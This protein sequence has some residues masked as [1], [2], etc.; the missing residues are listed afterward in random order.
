M[1]GNAFFLDFKMGW[2]IIQK[3]LFFNHS[4]KPTENLGIRVLKA[5]PAFTLSDKKNRF[6]ICP[7]KKVI[8]ETKS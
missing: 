7:A 8:T 1:L 5:W 3:L 6:P 4:V 2:S